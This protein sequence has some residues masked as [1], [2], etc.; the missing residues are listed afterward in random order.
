M[1]AVRL[2]GREGNLRWV[3]FAQRV[4]YVICIG[5]LGITYSQ[6]VTLQFYFKIKLKYDILN[7]LQEKLCYINVIDPRALFTSCR[8]CPSMFL[9][10]ITMIPCDWIAKAQVLDCVASNSDADNS[11][12]L[13]AVNDSATIY[14]VRNLVSLL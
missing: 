12:C 11:A 9:Y 6:H 4:I 8:F 13:R 7:I 14:Q 5:K 10:L 1:Q 3:S 2:E